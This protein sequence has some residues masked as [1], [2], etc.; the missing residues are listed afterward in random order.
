MATLTRPLAITRPATAP[1]TS[2][3]ARLRHAASAVWNVL[4]DFGYARARRDLAQVADRYENTNP[5]L[6]RQLRRLDR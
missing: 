4:E 6:A 3:R 1:A 5:E 2:L